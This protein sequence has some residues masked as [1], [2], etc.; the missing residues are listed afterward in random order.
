MWEQYNLFFSS[1]FSFFRE[2]AQVSQEAFSCSTP[3]SAGNPLPSV[4]LLPSSEEDEQRRNFL[5]VDPSLEG[6]A[7]VCRQLYPSL[8]VYEKDKELLRAFN[9]SS[10]WMSR[11]T[12]WA[13]LPLAAL[14]IHACFNISYVPRSVSKTQSGVTRW[15]WNSQNLGI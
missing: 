9:N 5:I 13:S 10:I 4:P 14:I 3:P 11:R 12:I 8:S 6:S 2:D 15:K 1:F 7:R